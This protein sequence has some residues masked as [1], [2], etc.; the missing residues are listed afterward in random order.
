VSEFSE[1]QVEKILV[2][3]LERGED[4]YGAVEEYCVKNDVRLAW[5]QALGAVTRLA[6]FYY[7]QLEKKYHQKFQEERLEI[8]NCTGNVSLKDGRPFP[9]LHI[10]CADHE[11]RASGGHLTPGTEVFACEVSIFVLKGDSPLVRGFDPA[12]GLALW[13]CGL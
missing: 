1:Y 8:L 5:V 3:R 12:T 2:G 4:L 7:D 13:N 10:T 9:H 11:G 6:Y